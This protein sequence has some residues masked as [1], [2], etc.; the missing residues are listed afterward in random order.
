[1][2]E[3]ARVSFCETEDGVIA[4]FELAAYESIA[5]YTVEKK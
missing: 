2:E 1:V 4:S 3:N 5:L